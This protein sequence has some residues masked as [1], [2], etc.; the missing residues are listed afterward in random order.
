M[1]SRLPSRPLSASELAA[2]V[3]RCPQCGWL[4][5]ECECLPDEAYDPNDFRDIGGMGVEP[6]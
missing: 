4:L 3:I 1:R 6:R 5:R 2:V